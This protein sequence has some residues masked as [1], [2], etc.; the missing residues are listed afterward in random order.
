MLG[1]FFLFERGGVVVEV[2][3][4]VGVGV[5]FLEPSVEA[6]LFEAA[7]YDGVLV[8]SEGAV[9][10]CGEALEGREVLRHEGEVECGRKVV[11]QPVETV[12]GV[13]QVAGEDEVSDDD[14]AE[15]DAVGVAF[16]RA[17]DL[18][19]HFEQGLR[20]HLRVVRGVAVA[21]GEVGVE[22]FEVGEV[23]V[24][25]AFER[26]EGVQ[27]FVARG[28]V[29]DDGVQAASMEVVEQGRDGVGIMGGGDES[30]E[31]VGGG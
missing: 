27:A 24:D 9:D 20:G 18:S 7:R 11:G 28:V 3:A 15:G 21:C 13:L 6:E 26:A 16:E 1:V 5:G 12:E 25:E 23:D 10:G 4:V 2:G 17:A 29:D 22:V 19:F 30:E 14:A 8:G 31:S